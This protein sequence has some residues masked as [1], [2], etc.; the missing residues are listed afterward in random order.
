MLEE[1]QWFFNHYVKTL[2]EKTV[3]VDVVSHDWWLYQLVSGNGGK[4]IYD[5]IPYVLYR[6]HENSTIG[7]NFTFISKIKRIK[8]IFNNVYHNWNNINIIA[9]EK[10]I[11]FLNKKSR[12]LL[13]EFKINKDSNLINRLKLIKNKTIERQS[14]QSQLSLLIAIIFKKI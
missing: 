9:I 10:N 1:I 13:L 14:F 7:G 12:S 5:E 4:I 8:Y 3:L 6:Q 2:L 11:K